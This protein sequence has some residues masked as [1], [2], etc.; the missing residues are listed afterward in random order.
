MQLNPNLAC[1]EEEF[2]RDLELT[3]KYCPVNISKKW[4]NI[5]PRVGE[6][7]YGLKAFQRDDG[8]LVT[9]SASLVHDPN[10]VWIHIGISRPNKLPNYH[11]MVE[12]KRVFIGEEVQAIHLY[13]KESKHIN[14]HPRCLHLWACPD[15][16]GL[17]DFGKWGSI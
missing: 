6:P 10:K 13:P 9:F 14:I 5:T 7:M 3:D 8:L 16:D 15:G 2:F 17:P 1:T 12:V 4:K 11:D